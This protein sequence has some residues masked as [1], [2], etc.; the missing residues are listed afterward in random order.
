MYMYGRDKYIYILCNHQF[1]NGRG[2]HA[3][4]PGEHRTAT[5]ADAS[6]VGWENFAGVDVNDGESGG[7]SKLAH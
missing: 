7:G 6:V 3:A 4:D 1:H 2:K 5:D